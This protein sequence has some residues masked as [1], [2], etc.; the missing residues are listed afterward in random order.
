MNTMPDVNDE[1][2]VEC[3][4]TTGHGEPERST[5]KDRHT[6]WSVADALERY[7][8]VGL[9]VVVIVVFSLWLP[10]TFATTANFRAIVTTQAV[11]SVVAM[12]LLIPLVAGRFDVSIGAT[13]GLAAIA[14]ASA[15][16]DHDVGLAV[17]VVIALIVG[18][19]VGLF[20]GVVV[21]YL[22]VSSIIGTLG[23][24]TILGGVVAAYSGG[25]PISGGIS[26]SLT[27][28]GTTGVAG[29]PSLFV[30]ALIVCICCWYVLTQTAFGRRLFAVGANLD[31][32]TLS[33]LTPRR[34]VVAGFVLAG[35][36]GSIAGVLQIS[37][38]GS[39][40]PQIA[41]IT[42]ILPSIA[43]VFLGAT[44]IRPGRY[45]VPGTLVALLFLGTTVSGLS[46]AGASP[47]VTDA[48][49]GSAII[50]AIAISAQF[51][52]RRTGELTIGS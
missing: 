35:V 40:D 34:L 19:A 25:T 27:E 5:G 15:M 13:T 38:Q 33:G 47:W 30:V 46:L 21:S 41:G 31:A 45:N 23:T 6:Q 22:G 32:A 17:A 39:A 42:F 8:L 48:F 1:S 2:A 28:L 7:G 51:R 4:E 52:R 12:G 3:S 50:V 29:V 26:A 24:A 18:A 9:F 49:N 11:A 10:E 20:N 44:T 36:L 43:A 37:A 14:A 16:S